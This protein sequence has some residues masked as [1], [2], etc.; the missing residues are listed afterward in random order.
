MH[1]QK[2]IFLQAASGFKLVNFKQDQVV[3]FRN[4][5]KFDGEYRALDPVGLNQSGSTNH[6]ILEETSPDEG[7]KR[8]IEKM[9]GAKKW[10]E[11][12]L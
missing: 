12:T 4:F 6:D 1:L 8:G 9:L 11:K 10:K 2:N 7:E 3:N 5:L